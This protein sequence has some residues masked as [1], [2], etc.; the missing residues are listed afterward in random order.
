M[1]EIAY[2]KD[3]IYIYIFHLIIIF[4]LYFHLHFSTDGIKRE[5]SN[6]QANKRNRFSIYGQEMQRLLEEIDRQYRA[7]KFS[8]RPRGPIGSYLNVPEQ[9]YRD[10]VENQIA[11]LLR[12]FIVNNTAD[13][14]LL[15]SIIQQR[16]PNMHLTIIT[17]KFLNKVSKYIY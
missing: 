11:D 12:A 9:K 17:A 6:L 10:V 1:Y 13:R 5:I 16:C 4:I 2:F 7:R 8:E 14:T 3:F 15:N